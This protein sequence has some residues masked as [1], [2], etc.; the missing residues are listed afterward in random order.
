MNIIQN[1]KNIK[2]ELSSVN[3]NPKIIA[4]SK[5][6]PLEHIQPLL[7]FGH[8]VFGENKV[9]EAQ[10]KWESL[11]K[12]FNDLELHLI[13]A[14]QRN[15]AKD[16]IKT[17][18]YI[19]SLD[20]E[21][22]ALALIQAEQKLNIKRKYFVQ[23]NTGNEKQK[24][25]IIKEELPNFIKF[26]EGKLNIIGLMCIPPV[27]ENPEIHFKLLEFL[28]K[29]NN[30]QNLSMGMTV[31]YMLACKNGSNHIRVGSKIFGIRK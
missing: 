16:A 14:L 1:F 2:E 18:D 23:I 9:Q 30:L 11:R 5:T 20:S 6:F 25:G 24:S 28:A 10:K 26:I 29:Q 12:K 13:G 27:D 15:K 4:V 8:R 17:F 7:D 22:L 21:K 19:H 3:Y 31:D